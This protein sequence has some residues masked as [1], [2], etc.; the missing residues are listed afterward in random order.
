[1]QTTLSTLLGS[2]T[3]HTSQLSFRG[4]IRDVG[5]IKKFQQQ[6]QQI[7]SDPGTPTTYVMQNVKKE[8]ATNFASRD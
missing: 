3:F 2:A 4:K 6:Q 7:D 1:M 8:S 5:P